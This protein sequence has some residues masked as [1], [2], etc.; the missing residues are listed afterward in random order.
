MGKG[1]RGR[2]EPKQRA[3]LGVR[4][5]CVG[6]RELAQWLVHA[7]CSPKS[8]PK[9]NT[10]SS[11]EAGSLRRENRKTRERGHLFF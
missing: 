3:H 5:G 9:Q 6:A 8:S 7:T 1:G 2:G 11:P 4:A 10:P